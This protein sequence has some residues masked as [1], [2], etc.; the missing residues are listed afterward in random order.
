MPGDLGKPIL[1]HQRGAMLVEGPAT[2]PAPDT[3]ER[4]RKLAEVRAAR[5]SPLLAVIATRSSPTAFG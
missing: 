2:V 1:D 4:D 3:T 5:E